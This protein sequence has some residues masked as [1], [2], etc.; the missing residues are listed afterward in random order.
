MIVENKVCPKCGSNEIGQGKQIG[1][2]KM[3][4]ANNTFMSL[5]SNIIADICTECGYIMEMRVEKPYKF[6]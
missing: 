2:G 5:G 1:H 3:L 6:K 4:P